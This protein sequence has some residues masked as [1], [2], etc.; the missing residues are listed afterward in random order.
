[1]AGP[2]QD[3]QQLK[4][5]LQQ[6]KQQ[7][8]E[9]KSQQ[10]ADQSWIEQRDR[11]A[12]QQL[13]EDVM[14]DASQRQT[15][16]GDGMT[17]G[18]DGSHF[19]LSNPEDTFYLEFAGHVQFRYIWNNRSNSGG[20]DDQQGFQ[21]RR[22]KFKPEGYVTYGDRRINFD[23]SLAGDR[24]S[25]DTFFEDYTVSTEL[26]NNVSIKGGRWKQPFALQNL[27]SSSR[28]LAVERSLVNETFNVDRSEGVMLSYEGE[29]FRVFGSLNNGANATFSDF[30]N[31]RNNTDFAVTG[32]GEVLL[33][34]DWGQV[35]DDS[36]SWTGEGTGALV[37]AGAHWQ[38][39]TTG[40]FQ[41]NNNFLL[42]TAD[43][44]FES[45]GFGVTAAAYGRHTD[46]ENTTVN[47]DTDNYGAYIEGGYMVVP[48]T[49]EPFARYEWIRTDDNVNT[50]QNGT[51][52]E[53]TNLIT[54]GVNWYQAKHDS[55]FT[56]DVVYALD[57]L[58]AGLGGT[59]TNFGTATSPVSTGL[60]LLNDGVG[61]DGQVAVRA[62][63]QLKW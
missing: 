21:F 33:A 31:A 12:T 28:Q 48:D 17:A 13:I 63:Y 3:V 5:E 4:Q 55:K 29:R 38:E 62:Q 26:F 20:D 42:W 9:L 56:L 14:A 15:L 10:Q 51:I 37:G 61:E 59:T 18:H 25:N 40:N 7:L 27:R 16:Q 19:Y 22:A 52:D 60:G 35:E 1:M 36:S 53:D 11:E 50:V 57:P 58:G 8:S 32:R 23:I 6:V 43:A 2:D 45:A 39:G 46:N 47:P 24:D 54:A 34:G 30:D 44:T 41:P 49:I